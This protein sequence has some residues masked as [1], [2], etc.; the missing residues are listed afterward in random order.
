M[1]AFSVCST[2]W[3]TR[4]RKT[5]QPKHISF[6]RII[7]IVTIDAQDNSMQVE[8]VRKFTFFPSFCSSSR[9]CI[10]NKIQPN[11]EKKYVIPLSLFYKTCIVGKMPRWKSKWREVG[12][13]LEIRTFHR[14]DPDVP[15]TLLADL[16]TCSTPQQMLL[17]Y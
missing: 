12:K 3:H 5:N 4:Q 2:A 11:R 7:C 16:C 6:I 1:H 13:T 14:G 17:L 9:Q 15:A 8:I 10:A